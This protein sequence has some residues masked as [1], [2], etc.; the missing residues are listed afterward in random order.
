MVLSGTG[1]GVS[2]DLVGQDWTGTGGLPSE[3]GHLSQ[4]VTTRPW[5]FESIQ[6]TASTLNFSDYQDQAHKITCSKGD[7]FETE[8]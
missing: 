4:N 6:G 8:R 7:D 3:P 5:K 1:T 2:L